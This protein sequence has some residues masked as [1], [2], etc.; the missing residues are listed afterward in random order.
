MTPF[1]LFSVRLILRNWPVFVKRA[2]GDCTL[3]DLLP[4]RTLIGIIVNAIPVVLVDGLLPSELLR[5][6]FRCVATTLLHFASLLWCHNRFYP[7]FC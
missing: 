2:R 5:G 7:R 3:A 1:L 4:P 6:P